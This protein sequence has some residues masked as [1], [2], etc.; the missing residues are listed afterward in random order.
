M[1]FT[2]LDFF[3]FFHILKNFLDKY[4][5]TLSVTQSV[6]WAANRFIGSGTPEHNAFDQF[7]KSKFHFEHFPRTTCFLS[8]DEPSNYCIYLGTTDKHFR[9]QGNVL[10]P[11]SNLITCD[12]PKHLIPF[13][14]L[15]CDFCCP[16]GISCS[17]LVLVTVYAYSFK[18]KLVKRGI[19]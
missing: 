19:L 4:L 2:D 9:D 18:I 7:W 5:F 16:E 14:T 13:E 12:L 6:F 17:N 8:F 11:T 1:D 15:L 3:F 10:H